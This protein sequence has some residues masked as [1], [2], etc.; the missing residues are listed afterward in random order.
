MLMDF[1]I[2]WFSANG[3]S[4]STLPVSCVVL[5]TFFA[6]QVPA[7]GRLQHQLI[8]IGLRDEL[9]AALYFMGELDPQQ[10]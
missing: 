7:R 4:C 8:V 10:R 5:I 9:L 1:H 2:E 6:M 3:L